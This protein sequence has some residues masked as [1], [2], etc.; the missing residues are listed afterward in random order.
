MNTTQININK[1]RTNVNESKWPN[2]NKHIAFM[3]VLFSLGTCFTGDYETPIIVYIIVIVIKKP[4]LV[5]SRG[6]TYDALTELCKLDVLV[7]FIILFVCVWV[8]LFFSLARCSDWYLIVYKHNRTNVNL[9]MLI[10]L[11]SRTKF[12]FMSVHSFN[13]QTQ[14]IFPHRHK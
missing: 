5:T 1:Q 13:E 12:M 11:I 7:F 2:T 4:G 14:T 10:P 8:A 3:F 6:C 9:F